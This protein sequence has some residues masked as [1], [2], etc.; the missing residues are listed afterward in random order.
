LSETQQLQ[1]SPFGAKR[2]A[3][4]KLESCTGGKVF[5][6][7]LIATV[8]AFIQ[9]LIIFSFGMKEQAIFSSPLPSTPHFGN[10]TYRALCQ[11]GP[12]D[13]SEM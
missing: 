3:T 6:I 2:T 12:N 5:V 9:N 8:L 4:C 10:R 11:S 13:Y 1:G 7:A